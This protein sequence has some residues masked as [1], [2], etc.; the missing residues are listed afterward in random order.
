MNPQNRPAYQPLLKRTGTG[1]EMRQTSVRYAH[2]TTISHR[3][4]TER[5]R[6]QSSMSAKALNR[7]IHPAA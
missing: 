6:I 5:R 7:T 2:I 1:N 4:S 3:S